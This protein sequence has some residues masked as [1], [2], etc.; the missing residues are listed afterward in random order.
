ME[1]G[2]TVGMYSADQIAALRDQWLQTVKQEFQPVTETMEAYKAQVAASEH[3][4]QVTAYVDTTT[5]DVQTWPG[6]EDP[7][8]RK[9]VAEELSRTR[10]AEDDPREISLALNA[11]YRKV[12]L[13]KLASKSESSVLDTL[14][15]K[16]A[17]SSSV[18]PGSA[19][20]TSPRPIK[21]FSDLPADAWR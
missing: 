5:A 11:A 4:R 18:N 1:D 7:E 13:P 19:A 12:V 9:A 16:A 14:R 21:S 3:A 2:R 8:T 10:V 17:A 15:R 20:P 6:M